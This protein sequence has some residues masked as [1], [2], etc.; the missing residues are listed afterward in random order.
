MAAIQTGTSAIPN[1]TGM[2]KEPNPNSSQG[3]VNCRLPN[4][5]VVTVRGNEGDPQFLVFVGHRG[6]IHSIHEIMTVAD[7]RKDDKLFLTPSELRTLLET[8]AQ[9]DNTGRIPELTGGR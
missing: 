5:W 6:A 7:R 3:G 1:L 2:I 4:G 8:V 9:F